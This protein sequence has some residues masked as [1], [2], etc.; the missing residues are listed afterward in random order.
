MDRGENVSECVQTVHCAGNCADRLHTTIPEVGKGGKMFD[1]NISE[2]K[3][4]NIG[5]NI[6]PISVEQKLS[7]NIFSQE[8]LSHTEGD[9]IEQDIHSYEG[10]LLP[11]YVTW[12]ED[13]IGAE[14]TFGK[15]DVLQDGVE[16]GEHAQGQALGGVVRAQGGE[17]MGGGGGGEGEVTEEGGGHDQGPVEEVRAQG[18]EVMGGGGGGVQGGIVH[19]L[20]RKL[21]SSGAVKKLPSLSNQ[22]GR[23]GSRKTP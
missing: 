18:G 6:L 3:H 23:W 1:S 5:S 10:N 7:S 11:D 16:G 2:P 19:T 8:T 17:V 21:E 14:Q 22:G 13:M 9:N 15:G 20:V 4:I 12:L